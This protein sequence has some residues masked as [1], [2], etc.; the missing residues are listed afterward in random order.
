MTERHILTSSPPPSPQDSPTPESPDTPRPD[1][2]NEGF[3]E[4]IRTMRA[5][6]N[7]LAKH[8]TVASRA[9]DALER[10][11]PWTPQSVAQCL[12]IFNDPD[13][14]S[15][16][17]MSSPWRALVD[18][19][20]SH[21]DRQALLA[22]QNLL[23]TLR[24]AATAQSIRFEKLS[25]SPPTVGLQPFNLEIDWD[26]NKATLSFAREPIEDTPLD[27]ATIL[28]IHADIKQSIKDRAVSS[29]KFF[30]WLRSAW[31]LTLAARAALP[32]ERVD[33]VDLLGPLSLL[34][35]PPDAWRSLRERDL[36]PYPRYLLAYQ[37]FRLRKDRC[38]EHEG[39]RIDLGAATG[40]STRKKQN[41][42]FIPTSPNDGQYYLSVRFLPTQTPPL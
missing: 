33:I 20:S 1:S 16:A 30:T 39:W 24:D 29:E 23:S 8:L 28:K 7:A 26:N 10:A 4:R 13:A 34:S 9:L 37:I 22:R 15:D 31:Q 35:T 6:F 3:L 14:L 27:T 41:V 40:A 25:D 17:Q 2:P 38:L 5:Q 11:H 36:K 32:D 18:D 12:K 21:C 42:L 19:L